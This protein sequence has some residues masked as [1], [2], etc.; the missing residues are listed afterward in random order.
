MLREFPEISQMAEMIERKLETRQRGF[1]IRKTSQTARNQD[2]IF[3][4]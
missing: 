1:R 4:S 2:K 3:S